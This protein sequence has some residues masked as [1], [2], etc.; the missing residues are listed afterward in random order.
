MERY[1]K[2]KT[3]RNCEL[4]ASFTAQENGSTLVYFTVT[5][6]P[7]TVEEVAS[8]YLWLPALWLS[9]GT[10]EEARQ[11]VLNTKHGEIMCQVLSAY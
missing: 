7:I 10:I 1:L 6:T 4:W 2:I 9:G 5:T 3:Y 11:R 8:D